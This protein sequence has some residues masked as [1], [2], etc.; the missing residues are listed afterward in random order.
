MGSHI[1][2]IRDLGDQKIRVGADLKTGKILKM[3][4]IFAHR[5]G[6]NEV[7]VLGG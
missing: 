5:I 6:N 2:G 4:S 3:G 7:G 1:L